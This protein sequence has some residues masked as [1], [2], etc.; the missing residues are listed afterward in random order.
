MP[1]MG[2]R[3]IEGRW[4]RLAAK[5]WSARVAVDR[6]GCCILLLHPVGVAASSSRSQVAVR[7][8]S[9]ATCQ[10][11]GA[12][13]TGIR[14]RLS[15]TTAIVTWLLG[16]R[17]RS[18]GFARPSAPKPARL[19]PAGPVRAEQAQVRGG[20]EPGGLPPVRA[21]QAARPGVGGLPASPPVP[22]WSHVVASHNARC[23]R[24]S[25]SDPG[26]GPDGPARRR[27]AFKYVKEV[28]TKSDNI[29]CPG[30]KGLG[31]CWPD[32]LPLGGARHMQ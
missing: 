31:F 28:L 30:R 21:R 29:R 5:L 20:A 24:A 17:V 13:S 18:G 32:G 23:A 25:A 3:V 2:T 27:R 11:W 7:K 10:T 9:A 14:W 19:A 4:R 8:A 22:G 16:S 15:L 26:Q 1:S 12:S 6:R